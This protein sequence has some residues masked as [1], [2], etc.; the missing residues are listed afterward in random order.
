MQLVV[1][2][3]MFAGT[4]DDAGAFSV[5]GVARDGARVRRVP[6]GKISLGPFEV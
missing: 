5:V 3:E 1:G 2:G 6:T 4:I